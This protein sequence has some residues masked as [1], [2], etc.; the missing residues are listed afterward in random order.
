MDFDAWIWYRVKVSGGLPCAYMRVL[1]HKRAWLRSNKQKEEETRNQ[2]R[3]DRGIEE[4]QGCRHS[5][6]QNILSPAA[7]RNATREAYNV[8][9]L[10]HNM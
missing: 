8:A 7:I 10:Y 3:P 2:P 9:D 1:T 6:H 5:E 4:T